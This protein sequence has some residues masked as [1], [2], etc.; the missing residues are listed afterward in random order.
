MRCSA[1]KSGSGTKPEVIEIVWLELGGPSVDPP[2]RRGFGSHV[3]EAGLTHEL[4]GV[5]TLDFRRE[6]LVCT[7]RYSA[8]GRMYGVT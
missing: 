7:M 6:G 4:D 1:M 8:S 3:L 2:T 5:V